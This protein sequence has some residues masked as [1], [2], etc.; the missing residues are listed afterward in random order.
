M[1]T[2][3]DFDGTEGGTYRIA[4]GDEVIDLVLDRIEDLPPSPRQGG[5][6]RLVFRGPADRMLPQSIYQLQHG[7]RA[8]DLF[9]VANSRDD[10]GT[11]YEAIFF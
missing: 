3:G 8:F 4:L 9:L 7:E 1:L 10:E 11:W 5:T 2:R 6:F